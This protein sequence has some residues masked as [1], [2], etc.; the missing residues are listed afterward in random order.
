MDLV[1]PELQGGVEWS[2][3]GDVAEAE[4]ARWL[5]GDGA[6]ALAVDISDAESVDRAF[7]AVA[8]EDEAIDALVLNAGVVAVAPFDDIPVELWQRTLTVNVVGAYLCLR[9]ALPGLRNAPPP[10]RVVFVSSSAAKLPG[11]Y[12]APYN[13]SKAAL[14]NLM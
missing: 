1:L 13:A 10:A 14:V 8:A 9:A 2:G 3:G 6:R 12:T 5:A 4:V 11:P 7:A